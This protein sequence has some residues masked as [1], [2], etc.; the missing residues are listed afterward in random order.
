M[1]DVQSVAHLARLTLSLDEEKAFEAQLSSIVQHFSEV[2]AVNTS[3]VEPLI[4]PTDMALVFREDQTGAVQS[5][6]EAMKNAPERSGNL[7]KVPPVV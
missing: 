1:I 6:E 5:A 3:N 4:T 2:E 7:F